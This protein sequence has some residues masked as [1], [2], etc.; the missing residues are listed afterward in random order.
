MQH[1]TLKRIHKWKKQT[2]VGRGSK[3]GKTSGRGTKGQNSRAGRKLRPEIRDI[4]KRLPK[5]RGRGTNQFVSRYV[6][7]VVI[8]LSVINDS[9]SSGETVNL[10]SLIKAKLVAR[11]PA[12][13]GVK[14]LAGGKIDKPLNIV[15]LVVSAS[16]KGEIEKA[17]GTV[18]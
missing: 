9:F 16:V 5:L 17:G 11:I 1:N 15:G 13:Q 12:S 4:I 2:V 3:R 8:K 14:I 18:K 7:P 10:A 6:K